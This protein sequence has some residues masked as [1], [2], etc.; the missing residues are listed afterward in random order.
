MVSSAG[1]RSALSDK[2]FWE[3]RTVLPWS[4]HLSHRP[5]S[6]AETKSVG[7][8]ARLPGFKS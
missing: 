6:R 2:W 4:R 7:S 8:R 5:Q 3:Q 1:P